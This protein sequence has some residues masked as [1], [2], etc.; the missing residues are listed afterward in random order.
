MEQYFGQVEDQFLSAVPC[1]WVKWRYAEE[2]HIAEPLV[3]E[4][5][6]RDVEMAIKKLKRHISPGID[7]I[8]AEFFQVGC[9]T[10]RSEIHKIVNFIRRKEELPDELKEFIVVPFY[11]KGNKTDCSNYRGISLL[12]TTYRILSIILLSRLIPYIEEITGD[13]QCGFRSNRSTADH[14]YFAFIKHFRKK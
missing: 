14:S 1:T 4:L 9:R 12:P 8:S 13:H 2:I 5:S 6:A 10:I 7:Q 3:P 11:K